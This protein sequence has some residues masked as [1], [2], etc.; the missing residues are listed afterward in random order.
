VA[1]A[2]IPRCPGFAKQNPNLPTLLSVTTASASHEII[3]AATDPYPNTGAAYGDLDADH[4]LW[5]YMLGGAEI[6]DMCAQN[7]SSFGVSSELGYAVQRS[8][9]N[10]A[11]KSG[12][13]PCVPQTNVYFNAIANPTQTI[14]IGGGVTS[15]AMLLSVGQSAV[16]DVTIVSDAPTNAIAVDAQALNP[17]ELSVSLDKTTGF[18][19][20][21]LK[22]TVKLLKAPASPGLSPIF[23]LSEYQGVQQMW[24]VAVV[25]Q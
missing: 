22:M 23:I 8:W 25:G 9:S 5:K 14:D 12:H 11:A 6:G 4:E 20:D 1:Y 24:P 18:N 13:D 21:K 16:L 17:T 10:Q 3:E 2:V 15:K 19:G 7:L